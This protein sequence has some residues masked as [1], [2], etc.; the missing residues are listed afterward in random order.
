MSK[1]IILALL[2]VLILPSIFATDTEGINL[3]ATLINQI[4]DP[5]RAGEIVEFRFSIQNYGSASVNDAII[6]LETSYPFEEIPGENYNITINKISAY[7]NSEYA[8]TTKYK[9][10]VNKDAQMENMKL[11]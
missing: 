5:V 7:Q 6:S 4:P 9:L 8:I 10:L 2:C 1:R 3:S 11:N